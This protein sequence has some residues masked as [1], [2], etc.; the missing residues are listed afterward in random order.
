MADVVIQNDQPSKQV[1]LPE[2][3]LWQNITVATA[4][5]AFLLILGAGGIA[6]V[7][8]IGVALSAILNAASIQ[9][10]KV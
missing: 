5:K 10:I 8:N 7:T 3:L 1:R 2:T 4:I 9:K 6:I